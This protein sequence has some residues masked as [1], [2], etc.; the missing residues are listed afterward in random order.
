MVAYIDDLVVNSK[1]VSEHLVDLD[2]AFLV[3]RKYKL[4]LNASKCSFEIGSG[5]FLGYM[6][7]HQG[8]EVNLDQIKAIHN[9]YPPWNPKEL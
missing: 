1:E 9:L 6:N 7:T 4:R 3:L 8:I 2:K 5:K